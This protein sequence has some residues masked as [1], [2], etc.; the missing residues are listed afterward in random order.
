MKNYVHVMIYSCEDRHC[1]FIHA[2][3]ITS[4]ESDSEDSVKSSSVVCL[5]RTLWYFVIQ[6]YFQCLKT[7]GNLWFVKRTKNVLP[8]FT[9]FLSE[10]LFRYSSPPNVLWSSKR[11]GEQSCPHEHIS[12]P[13]AVELQSVY[14][15]PSDKPIILWPETNSCLTPNCISHTSAWNLY[16]IL[17]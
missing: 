16:Y 1:D 14:T 9:V 10:R 5:Q 12:P 4:W 15:S 11:D 8:S 3:K 7:F 13:T 2:L 6:W 17:W